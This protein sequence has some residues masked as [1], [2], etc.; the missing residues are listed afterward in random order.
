MKL[1]STLGLAALLGTLAAP[2]FAQ[3]GD[4]AAGK[5]VFNQCRACHV[6]NREQNRVGPHLVGVVGREAGTVEGFRYS[7]AHLAKAEEGL[8]W[9]EETL[10]EYLKDPAA[11]IP[12]NKMVYRGLPDAQDRADLIAYLKEA[13]G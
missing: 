11:Y 2:A 4:P 13:G 10:D 3:E 1:V 12:G 5:R 8:V 9:N 7:E 6:I